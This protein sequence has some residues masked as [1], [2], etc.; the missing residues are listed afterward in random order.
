[1][2]NWKRDKNWKSS[3]I[4][5][6]VIICK[7][8]EIENSTNQKHVKIYDPENWTFIFVKLRDL[9]VEKGPIRNNNLEFR[10]DENNSH[11]SILFYT[12]KLS[13]GEKD[14]RRW[15]ISLKEFDK[16][17]CF[18]ANC[19]IQTPLL[20]HLLMIARKIGKKFGLKTQ[21]SWNKSI[22]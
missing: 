17:C 14:D 7:K 5:E 2:K 1:M 6:K 4:S 19:F 15:L 10:K 18:V 12:W 11:F 20:A 9:I 3:L 8:I 22:H 13:N 16:L 21:K